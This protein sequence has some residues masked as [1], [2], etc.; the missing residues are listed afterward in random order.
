MSPEL[1]LEQAGTLPQSL[2]IS[3]SKVLQAFLGVVGTW[4]LLGETL[5]QKV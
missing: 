5:P 1:F 2:G 3:S 4:S